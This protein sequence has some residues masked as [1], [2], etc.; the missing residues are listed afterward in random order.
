MRLQRR[1]AKLSPRGR[2]FIGCGSSHDIQADRAGD[3]VVSTIRLMAREVFPAEG[4]N[5]RNRQRST[6]VEV[7]DAARD[8][9][10]MQRPR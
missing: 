6:N 7:A 3:L 2:L 5:T 4:Q 1:L 10:C 9:G 8:R